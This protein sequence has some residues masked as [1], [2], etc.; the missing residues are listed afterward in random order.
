MPCVIV[1]A[2][3]SLLVEVDVDV[4]VECWRDWE[5]GSAL[6]R[7][8]DVAL[9]LL[10]SSRRGMVIE[11]SER[12]QMFLKRMPDGGAGAGAMPDM[13]RAGMKEVAN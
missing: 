10:E 9:W 11:G 6:V 13:E 4:V 5:A 7:S 3:E 8:F 2:L 1:L 12:V